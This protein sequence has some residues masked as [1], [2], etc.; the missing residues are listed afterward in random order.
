ML[1]P[2]GRA[3]KKA[4]NHVQRKHSP[5]SMSR[6]PNE[7]NGARR[8]IQERSKRLQKLRR[9]VVDVCGACVD[10]AVVIPEDEPAGATAPDGFSH[11][12]APAC[13]MNSSI[14]GDLDRE[15]GR[16]ASSPSGRGTSGATSIAVKLPDGLSE[17][18]GIIVKDAAVV[19]VGK[20]PTA[21][22][23]CASSM[24]ST[25]VSAAGIAV[26]VLSA[27]P[28]DCTSSMVSRLPDGLTEPAG[29]IS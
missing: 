19:T 26:G 28:S 12:L 21:G 4:L 1:K 9:R 7:P 27:A 11:T 17:L 29:T 15:Y 24:F 25:T 6:I 2:L 16:T 13:A 20:L 5:F 8:D 14:R 18:A 22:S 3:K 10:V 23:F